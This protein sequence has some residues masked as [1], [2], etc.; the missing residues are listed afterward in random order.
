[1]P[2]ANCY[3]SVFIKKTNKMKKKWNSPLPRYNYQIKMKILIRYPYLGEHSYEVRSHFSRWTFNTC[4]HWPFLAGCDKRKETWPLAVRGET[5][6]PELGTLFLLTSVLRHSQSIFSQSSNIWFLCCRPPLLSNP[7][8]YSSRQEVGVSV[9][10]F[11]LSPLLEIGMLAFS[12]SIS[13]RQHG[14]RLRTIVCL[15]RSVW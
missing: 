8:S 9:W 12:E 6:R 2:T 7:S 13:S 11:F 14:W 4:S 5:S 15:S 1:M 3:C 10:K